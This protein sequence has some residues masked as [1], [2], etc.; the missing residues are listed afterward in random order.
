MLLNTSVSY[1]IM[2]SF[3]HC[4][5]RLTSEVLLAFCQRR[6]VQFRFWYPVQEQ[7]SMLTEKWGPN[8]PIS[9]QCHYTSIPA[10]ERFPL[11]I[12]SIQHFV[13]ACAV[14]NTNKEADP[15]SHYFWQGRRDIF[16]LF[17]SA[18]VRFLHS[19]LKNKF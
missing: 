12:N 7:F 19:Y 17:F 3:I 1:P 14:R 9:L 16:R 10:I 5:M 18:H 6:R 11:N 15:K 8:Q 2:D 4:W 13:I